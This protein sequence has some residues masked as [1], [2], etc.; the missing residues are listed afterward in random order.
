MQD[1][2]VVG[3]FKG[4]LLVPVG[5]LHD[6]FNRA[7]FFDVGVGFVEPPC[8]DVVDCGKSPFLEIVHCEGGDGIFVGHRFT[9]FPIL[10][11]PGIA[12][13]RAGGAASATLMRSL[14][15]GRLPQTSPRPAVRKSSETLRTN[16]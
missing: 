16:V 4:R 9:L 3:Q 1:C 14:R 5:S 8:S 7:E 6:K 15:S 11:G 13:P 10:R 12:L 2:S